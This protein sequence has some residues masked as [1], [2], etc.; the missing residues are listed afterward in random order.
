MGTGTHDHEAD[1]RNETVLVYINGALVPRQ[2]A[3][4][5]VF[6]SGFLMGDGIWE[7]LRLY[8]GHVPY[9]GAHLDR[10]SEGARSLDIDIGMDHEALKRAVY[11]TVDANNMKDGVHIR[12][13]VTRGL[14]STP[15]QGPSV[16]IGPPTVVVAAG[17]KHRPRKSIPRVSVFTVHVRRGRPD[18]QDPGWNS[19]LN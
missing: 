2:Q 15:F 8:N 5:S 12:L 14:K 19:P 17:G 1:Q 13:M 7:G 6:D 4:V 11:Q 18:V 16:N 3:Q 10:L 9:L